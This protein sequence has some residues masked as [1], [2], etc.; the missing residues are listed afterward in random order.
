ME[1]GEGQLG[2]LKGTSLTR[3]SLRFAHVVLGYLVLLGALAQALGGLIV[4]LKLFGVC[5]KTV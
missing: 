2:G 5:S 3:G 4:L 1:N